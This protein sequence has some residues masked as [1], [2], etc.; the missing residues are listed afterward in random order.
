MALRFGDGSLCRVVFVC[1]GDVVGYRHR[2]HQGKADANTNAVVDEL[3]K[4]GIAVSFIGKPVDLVIAYAGT[5]Y[6]V[7]IKN[8]NGKD[9]RGKSWEDQKK[10]IE[11]WPG[12]VFVA[13]SAQEVLMR[14][15]F[16]GV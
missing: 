13:H 14:I 10:F 6:L 3:R 4:S 12:P 5:N 11:D 2:G 15:G 9:K 8:P 16:F 1:A 7:E